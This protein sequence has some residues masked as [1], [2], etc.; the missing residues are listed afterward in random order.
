MRPSLQRYTEDDDGY[1]LNSFG[2]GRRSYKGHHR[3]SL[4]SIA[5]INQGF[6]VD[7]VIISLKL[8]QQSPI[9]SGQH[10]LS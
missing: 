9:L 6:R 5:T 1:S 3:Q 7:E 10:V 8:N 4:R 2:N